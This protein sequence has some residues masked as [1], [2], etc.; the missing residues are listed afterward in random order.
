MRAATAEWQANFDNVHYF[1][2]YEMVMNTNRDTA[3]H[4][5]GRHVQ[6]EAVAHIMDAF[7]DAFVS[8]ADSADRTSPSG[9]NSRG[10][11][12]G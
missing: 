5:D 3:W 10:V 9:A 2:S 12:I 8:F 7:V 1:P 11:A 4:M 6:S